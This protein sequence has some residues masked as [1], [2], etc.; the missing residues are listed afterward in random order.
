MA[1]TQA[2]GRERMSY[3]TVAV[4]VGL[5]FTFKYFKNERTK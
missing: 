4:I 2:K 1:V 5:F 3:E